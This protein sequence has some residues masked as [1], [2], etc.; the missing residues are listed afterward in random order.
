M[1][2]NDVRSY[3][4][5]QQKLL[6]IKAV[7]L[8]FK[9]GFTQQATAKVLGVW[10]QH[11]VKWCQSF[12]NS[13]YEAFEL[14]RR[15]RHPGE[16]MLLKPWQCAVIVNTICDHTPKQLKLPFVL[17]ERIG[18]R[19]LI[20]QEFGI[21]LALRTVGEYLKRWGMTPQRPVER[22][23]ERNPQAVENWLN[24][25][26]PAI[27]ERAAQEDATILWGDE[28]GVQNQANAGRSYSPSGKTPVIRKSGKQLKVNMI[29]AITN[30][31]AVRFMIYSEK[32]NQQM[33]IRFLDRLISTF[34]G[35]VMFIIHNLKVHQGK[36]LPN[37]L[38]G[39]P[40]KL[41]FFLYPRTVLI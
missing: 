21:I 13:G 14:G 5:D 31:G 2:E 33:F 26:F 39:T 20:Q 35:K 28:T 4:T 19:E 10:R 6:R 24:H 11:V 29:S 15:G 22:A 18:V 32:M 7:D 38:P 30:R 37:G 27:K 9:N 17:W 34:S 25:E 23:Y 36:K 12:S 3:T 40:I 1:K 16:Q 41:N 8:V